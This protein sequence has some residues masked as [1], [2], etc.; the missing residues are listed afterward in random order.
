M[1]K[2]ITL[3]IFIALL[4]VNLYAGDYDGLWLLE[5]E[6]EFTMVRQNGD[7]LLMIGIEGDQSGWWAD[8]GTISGN[9]AQMETIIDTSN[10]SV[11]FT[12]IFTSSTKAEA[13]ITSCTGPT[14]SDEET[15][16]GASFV[17]N[18]IF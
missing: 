10:T 3:A 9:T 16:P 8:F 2:K 1:Y 5:G 4:S 6:T 13:V 17:F 18:K 14:C 7:Q 12:V 15:S 11:E